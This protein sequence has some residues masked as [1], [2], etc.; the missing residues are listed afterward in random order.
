VTVPEFK[1]HVELILYV[2][3]ALREGP[4]ERAQAVLLAVLSPRYFAEGST[5]LLNGAGAE[6]VN[7]A[8]ERAFK[9]R[10]TY[11]QQYCADPGVDTQQS[12]G[13]RMYLT[14]AVNKLNTM[15]AAERTGGAYKEGVKVGEQWKLSE[16]QVRVREDDDAIQFVSSFSDR[17]KLCPRDVP[18]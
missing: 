5:V 1:D 10:A 3:R 11:A 4:P 17:S 9:G 13:T 18:R 12:Q 8:L 16:L 7:R 14:A 2:H 6:I 15:M